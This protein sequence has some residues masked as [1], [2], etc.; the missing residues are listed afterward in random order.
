MDGD[1]RRLD[2]RLAVVRFCLCV[3]QRTAA[4]SRSRISAGMVVKPQLKLPR[5]KLGPQKL[6]VI[7]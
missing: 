5:Q 2:L 4:I 7:T 6:G 1:V 3:G